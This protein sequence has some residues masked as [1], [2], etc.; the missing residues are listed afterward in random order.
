MA[1]CDSWRTQ[2]TT[3]SPWSIFPSLLI[4]KWVHHVTGELQSLTKRESIFCLELSLLC[5][6]PRWHV[7]GRLP[8]L[9][10]LVSHP[11]A[12]PPSVL[13]SAAVIFDQGHLTEG[14]PVCTWVYT[15]VLSVCTA[16]PALCLWL[17]QIL[18]Q[19]LSPCGHRGKYISLQQL[20]TVKVLLLK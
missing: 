10:G 13:T 5:R 9:L 20:S 16:A 1:H 15:C 6:P 11:S 4:F 14:P 18:Q 19:Q 12:H 7:I 2:W 3:A 17:L 8:L